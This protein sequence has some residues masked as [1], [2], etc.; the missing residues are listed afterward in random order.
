MPAGRVNEKREQYGLSQLLAETLDSG[1]KKY[2]EQEFDRILEMNAIDLGIEAETSSL[3]VAV[4]APSEKMPLAAALVSAMLSEPLFPDEAVDR[5]RENLLDEMKTS[6][7]K[8]ETVVRELVRKNLFGKHPNGFGRKDQLRT[9]ASLRAD[10]LRNFYHKVCLSAPKTVIA[11]SGD[12]SWKDAEKW[13]RMIIESCRWSRYCPPDL[14]EPEFP[15]R[16]S[17][18]TISLPRE[19][20]CVFTALRGVERY[21]VVLVVP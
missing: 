6:L 10:D 4:N 1:C 17:R 7:L 3:M 21:G 9:I 11:F 13:S 12:I 20:A 8:P 15:K 14:P 2:D 5:E 19:Q 18:E 16:D